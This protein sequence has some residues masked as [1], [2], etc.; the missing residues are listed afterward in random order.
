MITVA[1]MEHA[2]EDMIHVITMRNFDVPAIVMRALALDRL[3]V[4]RVH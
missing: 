4:I 3:T 1:M 2:V